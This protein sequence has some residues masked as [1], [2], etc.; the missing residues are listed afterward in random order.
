MVY[1]YNH[2]HWQASTFSTQSQRNTFPKLSEKIFGGYPTLGML[3]I[4]TCRQEILLSSP[5]KKAV[6]LLVNF[7]PRGI[8]GRGWGGHQNLRLAHG[9][10][11]PNSYHQRLGHAW[12]SG[13]RQH[14]PQKTRWWVSL[15]YIIGD[16]VVCSTPLLSSYL[17]DS[18]SS[19]EIELKQPAPGYATL[20]RG[21]GVFHRGIA[22]EHKM[23]RRR[24]LSFHL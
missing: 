7:F 13:G 24:M 21:S 20:F 22:A 12:T 6:I 17:V 3:H 15:G 4:W 2:S 10:S 19:S 16:I 23:S 5:L 18:D 8:S 11:A 9:L 1:W 14:H